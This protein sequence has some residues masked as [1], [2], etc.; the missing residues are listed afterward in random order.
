MFEKGFEAG[1]VAQM[2]VVQVMVRNNAGVKPGYLRYWR[3]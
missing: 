1:I 3:Q 2:W